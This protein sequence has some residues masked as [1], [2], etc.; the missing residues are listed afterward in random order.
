MTRQRHIVPGCLGSAPAPCGFECQQRPASLPIL[1]PRSR[2]PAWRS[3]RH[4]CCR[5]F[6]WALRGES[7][8]ARQFTRMRDL[9][10]SDRTNSG[11][12]HSG[13]GG[14]VAVEGCEF[15]FE[16]LP[17][18]VDVNHGAH[19]APFEAL[20]RHG[21]GQNDSIVLLDHFDWSLLVGY[22]V[23]SRG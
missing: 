12:L 1:A 8:G 23:T 15:H 3:T 18:W 11:G 9:V 2:S 10:G 14:G 16:R 19:V 22:A 13:D 17:V 7:A 5:R 6:G 4:P 21:F 20:S